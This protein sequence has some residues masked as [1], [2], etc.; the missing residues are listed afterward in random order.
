MISAL[1][2]GSVAAWS[3][4]IAMLSVYFF[5][6]FQRSAI[7]G[8]IFD[9]IQMDMG[10]TATA[11]AGL[12]SMFLAIYAGS[13]LFIGMAADRFGGRRT[14]L[15]GALLMAVGSVWFPLARSPFTLYAARALTGFGASFMFLSIVHE[16]ETLFG[17]R[18]FPAV[19]GIV[20][21][22]GYAGGMTGTLPFAALTAWADWRSVLLGVG[23]LLSACGIAAWLVLRRLP[24]SAHAPVKISFRPM[25]EVVGSS[26]NGPMLLASLTSFSVYFVI[27]NVVGKKFL[28]DV[29]GLS[30]NRAASFALTMAAVSAAM[31]FLS[32]L[33]LK[34]SRHRRK[35][36]LL[37][38]GCILFLGAFALAMAVVLKASPWVYLAAY[39]MI[40]TSVGSSTTAS[41]VIKE[42]NRPE[43][44]AQSV[45]VLNGLTYAGVSGLSILSGWVLDHFAE[46][47][48]LTAAGRL[49]PSS[50]YLTLFIILTGIALFSFLCLTRVRETA[51]QLILQ[52]ESYPPQPRD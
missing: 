32:G 52:D 33:W 47:S 26:R 41:T 44:V 51:S 17:A 11:V 27:Q 15:W 42:M 34:L 13:Q 35:P 37:A 8:T 25:W 4:L 22:V 16:V 1:F 23:L 36:I 43:C 45:A 48:V 6:Y 19:M 39:M 5:S 28:Q 29:A 20:L 14:L 18:R 3:G 31:V 24:P 40:A 7:P 49:Y 50:A 2:Q 30:S 10:M 46:G 21:F 12:G 38:F 9:E